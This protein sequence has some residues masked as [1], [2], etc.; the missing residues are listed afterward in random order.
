MREEGHSANILRD[1]TEQIE[2]DKKRGREIRW[3]EVTPTLY[4]VLGSPPTILD[5]P[6]LLTEI[7]GKSWRLRYR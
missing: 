4:A 2:R 1:V 5:L 7:K 3:I 6:I